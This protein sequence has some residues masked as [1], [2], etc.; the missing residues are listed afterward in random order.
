VVGAPRRTTN[1]PGTRAPGPKGMHIT[2]A[3]AASTMALA[4]ILGTTWPSPAA[5]SAA[6]ASDPQALS[7]SGQWIVDRDGRVILLHGGNVSLPGSA[8]NNR[9]AP[10]SDQ[11]PA[12]MAAQGFNA[13]RLVIFL[14][15]LMPQPEHIDRRYLERVATTVQAYKT[16]VGVDGPRNGIKLCQSESV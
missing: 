16:V 15:D 14:S 5:A 9:K 4:F 12:R 2:A 7:Q 11:T 1:G 10:W 13:V 8:S 6:L 3:L